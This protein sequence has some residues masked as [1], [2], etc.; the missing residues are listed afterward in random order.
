MAFFTQRELGVHF[1]FFWCSGDRHERAKLSVH[2]LS[3][4]FFVLILVERECC[5]HRFLLLCL[6]YPI[7]VLSR[8]FVRNLELYYGCCSHALSCWRASSWKLAPR[9]QAQA[10]S[11]PAAQAA[12]C[13]KTRTAELGA[14]GGGVWKAVAN[15][16]LPSRRGGP[17]RRPRLKSEEKSQRKTRMVEQAESSREGGRTRYWPL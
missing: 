16:A 15:D 6:P 17:P 4:L 12:S 9:A 10:V 5:W 13:S 11:R 1:F 8:G 7:I 3:P 2:S 14:R